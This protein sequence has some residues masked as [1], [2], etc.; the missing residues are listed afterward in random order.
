MTWV[1]KH[2]RW[3]LA[4]LVALIGLV[5]VAI[6]YVLGKKREAEKLRG[7]MALMKASAKVEGL[8]AVRKANAVELRANDEKRVALDAE[9]AAVKRAG[10]AA[11]KDVKGK[12]DGS[13]SDEFRRLGY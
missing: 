3:L 11:V 13:I 4:A 10:V 7:E 8:Q 12:D 2:W 1:R 6:L 9:V 5:V